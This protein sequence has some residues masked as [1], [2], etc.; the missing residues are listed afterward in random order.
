MSLSDSA[1][2]QPLV[3]VVIIFLDAE[4]FIQ[5]AVESVYLQTY[6][7]WELLLVDDGSVD[8]S[9]DFA[10]S[11][12]QQQPGRVRFLEHEGHQNRGMSASRNLGI[13]HAAG[14]YIAF[15]DADDA[16]FHDA[17]QEQVA[18]LEAHPEAALVYGPLLW[19]YGW[20]EIAESDQFDYVERLGVPANAL[21]VP[22]RLFILF[23]RDKAAVTSGYLARK[24]SIVQM[25]GFEEAFRGEYEDQVVCAKICLSLPVYASDRCWYRYR[26]HPES[27]VM[28]G[29]KTGETYQVRLRFLTWLAQYLRTQRIND[30]GVRWAL[31][32]ELI[33]Y[34]HRKIYKLSK[35]GQYYVDRTKYWLRTAG[36]FLKS[37]SI[38]PIGSDR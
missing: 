8:S 15:L 32:L 22:P 20:S 5:E 12:A 37:R 24:K 13:Q 19:W 17:L 30:L 9:T 31:W 38:G 25:G 3:S 29:H 10:R 6:T 7:N 11:Y 1:I 36:R 16:W 14:D 35:R 26:Q 34:H 21:I 2:R 18:I 4:K 33:P 27:S 28:I 23:I